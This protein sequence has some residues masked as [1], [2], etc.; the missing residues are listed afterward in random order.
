MGVSL[1][2]NVFKSFDEDNM[3]NIINNEKVKELIK[4]P[5]VKNLIN[6]DKFD[7][8]KEKY[9]DKSDDEILKEAKD[10][11][12]KIKD[13]YG[14]QEYKKKIQELK[15]FEMFLNPEQKSKMRKFLDN[16]Q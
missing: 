15:K 5:N 14:E 8:F 6:N 2:A 3:K 12:Q 9:K 13:Q 4:D 11:G 16:L 7:Q 10:F 1:M